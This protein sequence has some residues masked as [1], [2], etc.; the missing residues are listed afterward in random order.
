VTRTP[1]HP[2]MNTSTLR[3]FHLDVPAQLTLCAAAGFR[4][5]EL[6]VR[7]LQSYVDAGGKPSDLRAMA[8]DL[9]IEV[10]DGIAFITWEDADPAV[11]DAEIEK[12]KREMTMLAA[13]G[14]RAVAA[15][16]FGDTEN[17]TVEEAAERFAHLWAAGRELGVEPILE[18][19]GHRGNIRTVGAAMAILEHSGVGEAKVLVDPI[20]VHKGGGSFHDL[21]LLPRGSI[22]IV[23]VN[24]FSLSADRAS[25]TDRDRRFPGDGDADLALFVDLVRRTGYDGYLSLELFI[26]DYGGIP[27]GDVA[28]RGFESVRRLI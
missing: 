7:D 18:M 28:R 24:D 5:I 16:P 14:C 26:E 23:H 27:A 1:F 19:W 3:P 15:P 2:G 4:G 10:F 25:L 8:E 11:R 21:G 12:A 17:V 20:H 22:G 9:G 13:V 6:W